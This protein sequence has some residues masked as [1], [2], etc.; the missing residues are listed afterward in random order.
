MVTTS[1]DRYKSYM[2]ECVKGDNL[3]VII[4]IRT[5]RSRKKVLDMK[6]KEEKAGNMIVRV[7]TDDEKAPTWYVHAITIPFSNL[8]IEKIKNKRELAEKMNF[9]TDIPNS[10]TKAFL[11]KIVK[12]YGEIIEDSGNKH[13]FRTEKFKKQKDQF[14]VKMKSF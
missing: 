3:K 14:K 10:D 1:E 5:I 11:K 9:Q 8:G 12:D 13:M 7:H 4:T 2:K 6:L